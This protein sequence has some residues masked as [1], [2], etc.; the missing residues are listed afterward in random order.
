MQLHIQLT[1]Y[2]P[3]NKRQFHGTRYFVPTEQDILYLRI[4]LFFRC[5]ELPRFTIQM[6]TEQRRF[7]LCW[8]IPI[9]RHF[10]PINIVSMLSF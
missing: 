8:S 3:Q 9:T 1:F 10:S 6:T 7:G 5:D 4:F 2:T